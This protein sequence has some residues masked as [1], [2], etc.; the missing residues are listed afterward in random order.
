MLGFQDASKAID[1]R[2]EARMNFPDQ[3]A[4]QKHHP[5]SGSALRRG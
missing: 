4:Y 1:E 3:T 5:D 2:N